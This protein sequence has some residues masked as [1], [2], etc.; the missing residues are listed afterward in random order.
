MSFRLFIYYCALCG[1]WAALVGWALGRAARFDHPIL[2]AG[3]K[4]LCLGLFVALVLSVVD[5]LW[6]FSLGQIAQTAMRVLAAVIVGSAGGM[7]GGLVGQALFGWKPWSVFLILGWTLTGS[8][9]G[10]SVGVFEMLT[11]FLRQEAAAGAVRKIVNG[12]AGG[13]AG[14]ML[15]GLLSVLLRAGWGILF[16]DK[17]LDALWSPSATGFVALGLCIGLLIGLAQVILKEA[18]VRVETGRRTGRE[19]M[20]SKPVTTIGRAE[21]CDIGLF[22]DNGVERLHARIVRS[23]RQYVLADVGTPGGTFLNGDRITE[24]TP[25]HSGDS[26]RVGDSVLHFGERLQRGR[27]AAPR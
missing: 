10:A 20:L 26:I 18:W 1:A 3:L 16:R 27:E 19:M 13:A 5:S 8:L 9:I 7:M 2:D 22:G 14:G 21:V 25:L 6:N 15:G 12:V 11:R 4:G 24:P 23:D 17:P